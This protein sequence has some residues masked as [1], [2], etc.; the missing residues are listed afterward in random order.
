[1]EMKKEKEKHAA[2]VKQLSNQ[3]TDLKKLQKAFEVSLRRK[4]EV[5]F[6]MPP[7]KWD[8]ADAQWKY[9]SELWLSCS[10][11]TDQEANIRHEGSGLHLEALALVFYD[12]LRTC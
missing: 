11:Q 2:L 10:H 5:L 7:F 12:V 3:I 8:S 4:D 1:M 9:S 6:F